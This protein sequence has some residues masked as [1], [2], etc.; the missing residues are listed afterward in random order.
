MNEFYLNSLSEINGLIERTFVYSRT[1]PYISLS[2]SVPLILATVISRSI[3]VAVGG[4]VLFLLLTELLASPA[5][6]SYRWGLASLTTAGLLFVALGFLQL[7]RKISRQANA[8]VKIDSERNEL[9]Q[10]L[11]R[12]VKWRRAAETAKL[13]HVEHSQQDNR[14]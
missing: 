10:L 12:E 5:S 6:E 13:P 1:F 8:L 7:R 3:F 11:D 2:I 4:G 9:Q 14:P